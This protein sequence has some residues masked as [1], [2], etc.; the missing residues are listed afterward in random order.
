MNPQAPLRQPAR[1]INE[2]V[3]LQLIVRDAGV[4]AVNGTYHR[5][6]CNN[7]AFKYIKDGRMQRFSIFKCTVRDGTMRWY[8]AIVADEQN[9]GTTDDIDFYVN[10]DLGMPYPPYHS[11]R[12][13]APVGSNPQPVLDYV[14]SDPPHD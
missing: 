2:E 1:R 14:Y 13:V 5:G 4:A 12:P 10:D 7:G 8:I 6:G 9:P 3:P 11:W